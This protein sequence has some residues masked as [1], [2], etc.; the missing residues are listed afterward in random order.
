MPVQLY[1]DA[2]RGSEGLNWRLGTGL[3]ASTD[4]SGCAGAP[5]AATGAPLG[6]C[7]L[8]KSRLR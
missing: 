1:W 3:V 7:L 6:S 4:P 8:A 2:V 5:E